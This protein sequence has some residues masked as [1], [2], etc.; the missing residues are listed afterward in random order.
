[1]KLQVANAQPQACSCASHVAGGTGVWATVCATSPQTVE[2]RNVQ[3][4]CFPLHGYLSN[5]ILSTLVQM[6]CQEEN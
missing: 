6:F 1:M 2:A 5:E 3:Q 4:M